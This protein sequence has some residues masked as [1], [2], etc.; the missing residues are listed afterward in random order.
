MF[1]RATFKAEIVYSILE[2]KFMF[3]NT[4]FKGSYLESSDTVCNFLDLLSENRYILPLNICIGFQQ[5][6]IQLFIMMRTIRI[7]HVIDRISEVYT[8]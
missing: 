6:P 3:K 8:T 2:H 1:L 7:Q 5:L 4:H